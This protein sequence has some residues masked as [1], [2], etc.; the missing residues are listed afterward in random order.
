MNEDDKPLTEKDLMELLKELDGLRERIHETEVRILKSL[1]WHSAPHEIRLS[2][3]EN[4]AASATKRLA[5]LEAHQL[6]AMLR[7]AARIEKKLDRRQ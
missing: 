7:P 5:N 1:G 2:Q 3:L 6:E 4:F